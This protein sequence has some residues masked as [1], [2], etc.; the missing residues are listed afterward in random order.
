MKEEKYLT[1]E[2]TNCVRGLFALCVVVH[3]LYQYSGLFH[4]SYV[5]TFLQLLGVLSVA[6]FFF[7][8]G[9]GLMYS[10]D[11]PGYMQGFLVKR[12]LP[13]YIFYALLIVMY[14]VW[15]WAWTGVISWQLILQSF[16]FGGT[17]VTNGWSLQATFVA[18]LLYWLIFRW[19]R[20]ASV[21]L[22]S[23]TIGIAVYCV[24]CRLMDLGINWYQTIPC[25]AFGMLYCYKKPMADMWLKRHSKLLLG[26]AV[27]LCGGC[28]VLSAKLDIPLLFHVLYCICFV[29]AVLALLYMLADT[30]C[31]NNR[32][33]ALCGKYSLEI[34]VVHGLFL[35]LI[36]WQYIENVWLYVLVV[37][38]GTA[39]VSAAMKPVHTWV[40]FRF[41]KNNKT[42]NEKKREV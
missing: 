3:H 13:L 5:G 33:F 2:H 35:P 26:V 9:Y 15:N 28:F 21:R 29:C 31:I 18:Y 17:V 27:V 38:V 14:S 36:K 23:F 6:A 22:W 19:I 24:I 25:M 10:A 16:F 40:M 4:D 37:L 7:L 20:S 1:K 11:R 30:H 41:V 34:Y 42:Q 32:F 12:F 8:S 39:L